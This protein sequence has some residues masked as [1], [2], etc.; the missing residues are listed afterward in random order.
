MPPC[1]RARPAGVLRGHQAHEG[2]QLPR[3]IEAGQVAELGDDGEGDDPLDAAQRLQRLDERI[4]PPRGAQLLELGFDALQPVDLFIDGAHAFLEDD[5]LRRRRTDDLGQV[6]LVR[7]IP[8]GPSDVVEP[9]A[10]AGT[11]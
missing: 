1:R 5:L 11:P 4:A 9:E 8:V 3:I 6:A 7:G 10:Q 2:R